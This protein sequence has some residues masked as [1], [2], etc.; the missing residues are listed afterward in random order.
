[1]TTRQV[2]FLVWEYYRYRLNSFERG[3]LK[4]LLDGI[5]GLGDIQ[6][7]ALKDY[8]SDKQMAWIKSLGVKFRVIERKKW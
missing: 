3:L 7:E 1:M 4:K 2:A 6:D 5:C 8:L